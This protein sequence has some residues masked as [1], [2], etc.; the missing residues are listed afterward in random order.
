MIRC[1]VLAPV[2]LMGFVPCAWGQD[3]HIAAIKKKAEVL[4]QAILIGNYERQIDLMY[5]R[6][7]TVAGGRKALR[8]ILEREERLNKAEGVVLVSISYG[9]PSP[10]LRE[11]GCLFS[12]VPTH[13]VYRTPEGKMIISEPLLAISEDGGKTWGF[14]EGRSI[15]IET[16]RKTILPRLPADLRLPPKQ[17]PKFIE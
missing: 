7:A 2:L 15:E 9:E 17:S 12:L 14:L 3:P 4:G 11:G 10:P 8:T 16:A 13:T 5:H 6:L 1:L